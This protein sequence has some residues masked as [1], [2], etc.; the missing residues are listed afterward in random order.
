MITLSVITLSCNTIFFRLQLQRTPN[1]LRPQQPDREG[2]VHR[3]GRLH[4]FRRKSSIRFW[5]NII[6]TFTTVNLGLLVIVNIIN[7]LTTLNLGLLVIVNIINTF[8]TVNLGLLVIVNIINTFT[9]A[10]LG[11]LVIVNF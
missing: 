11:L 4:T 2:R 9:T 6:N 1:H 3:R 5:V 10:N 7:T 8:T